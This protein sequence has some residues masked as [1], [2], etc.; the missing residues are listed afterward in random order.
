MNKIEAVIFDCD[1]V[2]FD[3]HQ[4]NLAY[5]N[6]IFSEFGFPVIDDPDSESAHICHT[7][8][9]PVVLAR[10]M[11]ESVVA[12]ALTFARELDYREFTP[13]MK[14]AADLKPALQCLA[15]EMPLAVATNRGVSMQDVLDHF[16]LESF[17]RVVVTSGHVAKPK[18]A[19]DMLFMAAEQLGGIAPQNCLFVGDSELDQQA[20][21]AAGMVFIAF[22]EGLDVAQKVNSHQELTDLLLGQR[23]PGLISEVS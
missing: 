1:G 20:A 11:S 10:L 16:Q 19:P 9:S 22:G 14:E 12:E 15:K 7:A 3:S 21:A 18:P 8:S 17:F 13:L 2:L 23:A 4:A 6:R 5:Y